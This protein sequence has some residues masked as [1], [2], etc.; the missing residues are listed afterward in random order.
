MTFP[1]CASFGNEFDAPF[2]EPVPT[3]GR[4]DHTY[5]NLAGTAQVDE[6]VINANLFW[7]PA[8]DVTLLTAFRY[9][10][11]DR[12]SSSSFLAFEPQPNVAPFSA[13]N[14]EGGFHYGDGMI[15]IW[16]RSADY[17]RFAESLE[18]RYAG[19]RDWLF[20]AEGRIGRGVRARE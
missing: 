19:C 4:S 20:Y 18:F 16:A 14:P 17:D 12:D 11:E 6:H 3:L 8:K 5:L 13:L 7:L 2:G 1:E 9:T 15:H 10:H